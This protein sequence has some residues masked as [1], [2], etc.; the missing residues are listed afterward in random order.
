MA[1][2]RIGLI[3]GAIVSASVAAVVI[4][5][6]VS[7][8]ERP[9]TFIAGSEEFVAGS[10]LELAKAPNAVIEG[11]VIEVGPG[12]TIDLGEG[13]VLE[14]ERATLKVDRVIW[15]SVEGDVVNVEE[16]Y[17]VLQWPWQEGDTG[18]YFLH[19]KVEPNL[20]EPIYRLTSTQGRFD[21]GRSSV[22]ASN[23][24]YG[25]VKKL[26]NINPNQCPAAVEDAIG[27]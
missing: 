27:A 5:A 14:Y 2:R 18:I 8:E 10:L 13:D 9:T 23:D 1:A 15:G 7:R 12:R 4:I 17:N 20:V 6:S 25:W 22:I 26:E 24:T 3:G 19:L 11:T 21:L 16:Y